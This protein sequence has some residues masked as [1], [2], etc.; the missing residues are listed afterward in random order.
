MSGDGQDKFVRG[1]VATVPMVAAAPMASMEV[2]ATCNYK[3]TL[4]ES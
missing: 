1:T 4:F 3:F 2:L